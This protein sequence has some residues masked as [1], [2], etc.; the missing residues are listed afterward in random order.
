MRV[1]SCF[2]AGKKVLLTGHTGFKGSWL[3]QWLLKL[4]AHV[5]G[6]SLLPN[7]NQL[8]FQLIDE[9]LTSVY[10]SNYCS[11]LGNINDLSHLKEVIKDSEPDIVFHLA[12]Q[13]LVRESY[14]LPLETW[15]TNVI[16]SLNL[17]EAC[18]QSKQNCAVIIVTT[19]KV[20]ENNESGFA[21]SE[22]DRL[23]GSD[24]YSASKAALEIAV[25]SWRKSFCN[26]TFFPG[27]Q[28]ISVA[29]ARA[30]NVVGGGDWSADRIFPDIVRA[31]RSNTVLDLRHPQSVRPWQHVLEP[32]SGYLKLAE[33]LYK[34]PS[35]HASA[36]NFGPSLES[37]CP[38]IDLV[39]LVQNFWPNLQYRILE[40]EH[41]FE[42][43]I[44]TLNSQKA[45]EELGWSS[46][47]SLRDTVQMTT[48]W[49]Q[50][51]LNKNSATDCCSAD[52]EHFQRH[53]VEY[54][55]L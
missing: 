53:I 54:P 34:S 23:G 43:S 17:L 29:T 52:I 22:S 12:A 35:R 25:S 19:D 5:H 30:G 11:I 7:S 49:Y 37:C 41:L 8:L 27:G 10:N 1:D 9:D 20:Y 44:L 16:G 6:Y 4:G 18:K 21:F 26:S 51:L 47:L 24:P 28:R 2:W 13:P 40:Q 3:L 42:S 48:N 50:A 45:H 15:Q 31:I 55:V 38:V 46:K 36:Y 14:V 33:H 32:L 39:S